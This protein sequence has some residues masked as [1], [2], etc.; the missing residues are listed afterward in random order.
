ISSIVIFAGCGAPVKLFL[1]RNNREA[2]LDYFKTEPGELP[3]NYIECDVSIKNSRNAGNFHFLSFIRKDSIRTFVKGPLGIPAGD[4][5]IIDSIATIFIAPKNMA[6]R[7]RF[8]G[9]LLENIIGVSPPLEE[10]K[11]VLT[12][13]PDFLLLLFKNNSGMSMGAK[14]ITVIN[15]PGRDIFWK[16]IIINK[17]N[18]FI[19]CLNEQSGI[20]KEIEG[21]FS[22]FGKVMVPGIMRYHMEK[23][24]TIIFK[25]KKRKMV[26]ILPV[27]IFNLTIPK[28]VLIL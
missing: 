5:L 27:E 21:L 22:C 4:I 26:D 9:K 28:G 11:S 20:S 24:G 14:E 12:G 16:K 8:S 15:D 18:S 25:Y 19:R 7:G 2:L 23:W 1:N 6:W 13:R 17:E 10:M 3:Y